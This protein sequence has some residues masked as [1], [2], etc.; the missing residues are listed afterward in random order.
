MT[1][2]SPEQVAAFYDQFA[3]YELRHAF[4][5]R[6]LLLFQKLRALGLSPHSRVLELGCGIGLI[7]SLMAR[8]VGPA[9][10]IEA[11][12]ISPESI[13][14][15][16]RQLRGRPQ[17]RFTVSDLLTYTPAST[18]YDFVTLFD[19]LEHIPLDQ[20]AALF[21]RV[22]PCLADHSRLVLHIPHPANIHYLR[23]HAPHTLQVIDQPV[24]VIPL[25]SAASSAGLE[26]IEYTTHSIWQPADYQWLIL[27]RRQPFLPHAIDQR[28]GLLDK[29]RHRLSLRLQRWRWAPH[30]TIHRPD[31]P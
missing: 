28:R 5:E 20:H 8:V 9:G 1:D 18:G 19:V 29:I 24:E 21:A 7:T 6:Q 31:A 16:R 11:V 4:N 27:R 17:V 13:A 26:L 22:A 23:L 15:A 14:L 3:R 12:D 25:L 2:P 30:L 10:T